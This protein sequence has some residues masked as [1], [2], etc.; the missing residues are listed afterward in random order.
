[1][2]VPQLD[3]TRQYQNI[4]PEIDKAILDVCSSGMFCLGETVKKFEEDVAEYI[5]VKH[6]IGV[7]SGSA[8]LNLALEALEIGPGD[9][10]IVPANTYIATVFAVSHVGATPVFVDHD[11]YYN[12]D[13]KEVEKAITNKT[14]AVIAVHLYGQPCKME[15]LVDLCNAKGLFLVE[16]A[17]QAFGAVYKGKKVGSFGIVSCVSFYPGKNLGAYGDGGIILTNNDRIEKKLRM[18]RNDGQ[19]TKYHHDIIGWNERLDSVQAAILNV[20]LKYIDE[21]NRKRANIAATYRD[22]IKEKK[23]NVVVPE[24]LKNVKHV[25]HQ[26][27]IEI[28]HKIDIYGLSPRRNDIRIKLWENYK[29]GTGIH[30]PIPVH[31]QEC[32]KKYEKKYC[33][34]TEKG[35]YKLL[36]LP[37]FPELT[38]EEAKHV[39]D[40][41]EKCLR[42]V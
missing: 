30:Y 5:G 31:K 36:S 8:S 25:Y 15:E 17:A 1:M 20:K 41:L 26:Y 24:V 23:L 10:V 22:L 27:V 35:A 38:Y 37:M 40:C 19:S 7:N 39:I 14:K 16:D 12:I 18:L 32:Y 29:I 21:W 9:E 11:E 13:P 4:K 3:L 34:K 33:P 2:K 42:E 6:A 28:P